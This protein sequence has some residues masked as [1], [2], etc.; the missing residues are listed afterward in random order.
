MKF[1]SMQRVHAAQQWACIKR[2][3][4][5]LERIAVQ[6]MESPHV[7]EADVH[8]V[9]ADLQQMANKL[10]VARARAKISGV[11]LTRPYQT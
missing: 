3:M 8:R 2:T 9:A 6:I 7:A 1:T 10:A 11:T 5:Q 4:T